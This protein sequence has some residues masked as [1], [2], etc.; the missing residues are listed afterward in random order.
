[1]SRLHDSGHEQGFALKKHATAFATL[2]REEQQ[3]LVAS[4]RAPILTTTLCICW[5]QA[6]VFQ[7]ALTPQHLLSL[8]TL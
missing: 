3:A 8:Q 4:L 5:R 1:M 2:C 6:L 7:Y